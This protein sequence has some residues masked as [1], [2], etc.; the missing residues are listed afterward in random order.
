MKTK[1]ILTLMLATVIGCGNSDVTCDVSTGETHITS[2]KIEGAGE[3]MLH[4]FER[5]CIAVGPNVLRVLLV[6]A[7]HGKPGLAASH[8]M[9]NG[10]EADLVVKT[11]TA[12]MP[13]MGHGTATPPKL[14]ASP[15]NEFTIDFQMPGQWQIEVEFSREGDSDVIAV[16]FDV[17]VYG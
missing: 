7:V 9:A 1:L 16:S 10:E 15:K 13:A 14:S 5:S 3:V 8:D 17:E 6:E 12:N 4:A 2:T 11:V